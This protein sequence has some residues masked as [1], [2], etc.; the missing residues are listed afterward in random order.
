MSEKTEVEKVSEEAYAYT[1]GLKIK[2]AVNIVKERRL[3]IPGEILVEEGE[4]VDYDTVVARTAVPGEPVLVKASAILGVDEDEVKDFLLKEEGDRVTKGEVIG[5][6]RWLF[7]IINREVTSPIEGEI[8]S[9]SNITGQ[10]IIRS[11]PIPVEVDAYI[12]G[13]VIKVLPGEGVV[14]ETEAAYIQGIFGLGG[15]AHGVLKVAVDSP[16]EVLTADKISENDTGRIVVG[17]SLISLDAYKKAVKIG[18]AGLVAGG[19]NYVDITSI[20]GSPIGVAITGEEELGLTLI[21]TEGFGEMRMSQR[22]FDLLK[23]FEG[24]VAAINGATQIRAGVMRPEIIIPHEGLPE[25]VSGDEL[26]AGMVPGTPIRIIREP[27]FG[28]IGTVVSLPVE[29]QEVETGSLVRV[30]VAR[31]E[32]G[33]EVIVPRANVE[34]IEE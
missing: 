5:R 16:D 25:Q 13:R 10:I 2:R 27:Y 32:D 8:E 33:R 7:G 26:A 23:S 24:K 17:G 19:M 30:L 11:D 12:P 9:I 1:P 4:R 28:A 20:M 6:Y 21:I 15:A 34:I 31:L 14:I 29:L 3:P 22:T 18:V